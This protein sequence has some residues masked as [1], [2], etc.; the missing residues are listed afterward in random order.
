M[1]VMDN[2]DKILY[3]SKYINSLKLSENQMKINNFQKIFEKL[4]EC[5][6]SFKKKGHCKNL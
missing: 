6:L 3:I 1:K 5:I 4:N 2:I